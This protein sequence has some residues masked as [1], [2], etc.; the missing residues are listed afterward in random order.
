MTNTDADTLQGFVEGH[1]IPNA[2]VNTDGATAYDGLA[3]R[4]LVRHSVGEYV[5]DMVHTNGVESFWS[6][7]KRAHKGTFPDEPQAPATL[8]GRVRL[9][10]QHSQP[11]QHRFPRLLETGKVQG[12]VGD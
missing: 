6:M 10:A 3:N 11:R 1:R 4:Q 7:L 5:R 8:C 2:P 12:S 9:P